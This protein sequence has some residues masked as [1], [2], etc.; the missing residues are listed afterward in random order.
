VTTINAGQTWPTCSIASYVTG[1]EGALGRA[2]GLA[3]IPFPR[4]TVPGAEASGRDFM[5]LPGGTLP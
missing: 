4:A 5:A 1:S 2:R 3:P